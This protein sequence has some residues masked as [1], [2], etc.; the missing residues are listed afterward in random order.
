MRQF[1]SE[2]DVQDFEGWLKWTQGIDPA[3]ATPETLK[4]WRGDYDAVKK[5]PTPKVGS[6]KLKPLKSGEYRYAVAVR[7]GT[8]LWLVLWVKWDPVTGCYV[9]VPRGDR[10]WNPHTSYHR[11]GAYHS[12]TFKW[13]VLPQKRQPLSDQ[14]RGTEHLGAHG[15]HGPKSVGAVCDP[16]LFTGIVEVPTGVLGPRDGDIVIDLVEPGC[17]P[18]SHPFIEL[19]VKETFKET[20]PWIVIRVGSKQS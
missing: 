11:S 17:E 10:K 19:V 15:G 5:N 1:V 16:A 3:T 7:E 13:T 8:D 4:S 6:M 2:D 9:M 20:I 14:F 12:K 18:I